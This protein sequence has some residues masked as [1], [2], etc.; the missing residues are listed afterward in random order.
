MENQKH[1]TLSGSFS[2]STGLLGSWKRYNYKLDWPFLIEYSDDANK[3]KSRWDLNS[4]Q[5]LDSEDPRKP[6]CLKLTDSNKKKYLF[7]FDNEKDF[8]HWFNKLKNEI[9]SKIQCPTTTNLTLDDFVFIRC[10]GRGTFGKVNL[11][12]QKSTGQLFALKA[13]SKRLLAEEDNIQQI[14]VER[15]ILF[16][17]KHPFL[18]SASF[19]FQTD[20]KVFIGLEYVPGGELFGRLK[21]EGRI[22]ESRARLYAAEMLLGLA[23]LHKH[24]FIYRDMK[25]ENI[26]V[27]ADGHLKITDFGFAK[28]NI[29]NERKTTR[30]FC[31]TPE[32]LAPE[33]LKQRPYTRS[34]DWWSYGVILYE[35]LTGLPPFYDTNPK[36]MYMGILFDPLRFPKFFSRRTIDICMKLL[37]RDAK[38]RLGAGPSDA[39]EIMN[40]PF[41]SE[42]NWDYVLE[43]KYKPEWIPPIK[44]ET[45]T[46]NFDT[47][48]TNQPIAVSY[49]DPEL[50]PEDAQSAFIGFTC[51][52][53]EQSV[54]EASFNDDYI[55]ESVIPTNQNFYFMDEEEMKEEIEDKNKLEADSDDN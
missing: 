19:T 26:L 35:M 2:R 12:R 21:E 46:S 39:E 25:P 38:R 44:D 4:C 17:N 50:V 1:D 33:V 9:Q 41:F 31:G 32:Y 15:E 47:E 48:F 42:I 30:T 13:M 10:I 27:D 53:E 5:V 52:Q 3:E 36:K 54:I 20:T 29:T 51:N 28:G 22:S 7:K 8:T 45:D 40:H 16:Q 43:K 18:V 23:H 24:G 49:E 6:F 34:V 14:L 55:G 11:V 37:D